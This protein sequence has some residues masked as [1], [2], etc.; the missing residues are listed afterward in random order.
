M[1][2]SIPKT[3]KTWQVVK[4]GEFEDMKFAD[5]EIPE[6]GDS[7]CLVKLEGAV[8]NYRDLIIAKGTYPFG[9]VPDVVPGSDGAGT[10]VAVGKNVSRFQPGDKVITLFNQEHIGGPM[11]PGALKSGL[12]GVLDGTLREYGA[13]SEQGLVAMPK[14]LNAVEA[15]ALTCAGLTAWNSLFGLEGKRLLPGQWVLTQGTGGVSMFAL[16][17]AKAIGAKVIATTSS[18]E[19]AKMLKKL[20][21]DHIINYKETPEWGAEAKKLA[22]GLGVHH[23]VEI[24]GPETMQQSLDAVRLDGHIG[25][26]GFVAG[27]G[28]GPSFIDCLMKQ[29]TTRGLLVGNRTMMEEMCAAV[30]AQPEALRPII[31]DK[32][33]KLE[34]VVDAYKYQWSAGHIGNVGI[35]IC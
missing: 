7:Q 22:E 31:D 9:T 5:K 17:F 11:V 23:I 35:E 30:E 13:F 21:A 3:S 33:F 24:G 8:L 2:Q 29:V 25:I 4:P 18:D 14:S 6:V 10:V 12:G 15:A 26:I 27:N 32:K 34:E 20:G 1:S 28:S 19:K 16:Q